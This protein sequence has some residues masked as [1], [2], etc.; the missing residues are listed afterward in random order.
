MIT[1]SENG[2]E[3]PDLNTGKQLSMLLADIRLVAASVAEFTIGGG[4]GL[5]MHSLPFFFLVL[6]GEC[7]WHEGAARPVRL[8][9]GD[10]VVALRGDLVRL[11]FTGEV[12]GFDDIGDVWRAS[13]A[14]PASFQN[15]GTPLHLICGERGPACQL[16]GSALVFSRSAG[17]SG[18][19]KEA[20]PVLHLTAAET[21][22]NN[23][24]AAVRDVLRSEADDPLTG[25]DIAGSAL[26]QFL[27]TEQLKAYLVR[28]RA[29]PM[30]SLGGGRAQ[31]IWRVIQAVQIDPGR[32][33][34]IASMAREAA[35]SR[36]NFVQSF[37]E[38]T[39]TTPFRFLAA[40]RMDHAAELLRGSEVSVAETATLCGYQSQRAFRQAFSR[41]FGVAPLAFRKSGF[42]P[43]E[44]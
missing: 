33:W 43:S 1:R 41:A 10:S 42:S 23:W 9:V 28:D 22:L 6:D 38:L 21:R 13:G 39:G 20:P 16:M 44:N 24:A 18:L 8:S 7:Y 32:A 26:A 34:T 2:L 27:L 4:R 29:Q 14:P 11:S 15:Y 31:R 36:T 17:T 35:M 40:C 25:F 12:T 37:G 3:R 19:I 5:A 30:A